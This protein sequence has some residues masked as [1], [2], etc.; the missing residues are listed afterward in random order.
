MRSDLV[1]GA[2]K[3]VSNRFL[4]AKA[5]AKATRGL[6]KPGARVE[7]TI[8]DVLVCCDSVNPIADE[9]TIRQ[10]TTAGSRR[11]SPGPPVLHRAGS[12]TVPRLGERSQGQVEPLRALIA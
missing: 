12:F 8:N 6:H 9:N 1:F 3:Q 11:N 4:L 5:L 10:S 2:A 7:D